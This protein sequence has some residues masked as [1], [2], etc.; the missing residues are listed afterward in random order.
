[1]LRKTGNGSYAH[2]HPLDKPGEAEA[3]ERAGSEVADAALA[4]AKRL[5]D[6]RGLHTPEIAVIAGEAL[7]QSGFE[8]ADA[9][10][11]FDLGEGFTSRKGWAAADSGEAE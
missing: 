11:V 6:E 3:A 2:V 5:A 10:G 9:E 1:M 7:A 8:L 4:H